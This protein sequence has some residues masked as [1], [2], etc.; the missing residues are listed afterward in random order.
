MKAI[1][2]AVGIVMCSASA[3]GDAYFLGLG[4]LPGSSAS[5][6]YAISPDGTAVVGTT[7]GGFPYVERAFRWTAETGMVDLGGL[8]LGGDGHAYGVC[9]DGSAVVG[10]G[11]NYIGTQAFRWTAETGMVSLGVPTGPNESSVAR[12]LSWDGSVAVGYTWLFQNKAFRWQDGV[13]TFLGDFPGGDLY[14]E[15]YG[16]SADGS[17]VVGRG[18]NSGGYMA[19]RWT[20]TSGLVALGDL[21][22]GGQDSWARD[23]SADGSVIVGRGKSAYGSEAFQWTAPSADSRGGMIGLGDLPGGDF[24]SEALAVSADG[25][26]IVGGSI[27]GDSGYMG[28]AFIWDAE[29]GMRS[30]RDVLTTEYGFDLT[31]WHLYKATGISADGLTMAGYGYNPDRFGTQAW[32]AHIPEP[33]TLSLL[34]LGSLAAMRRTYV[35]T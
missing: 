29:N 20:P 24:F 4:G 27:S 8:P 10:Y 13:T 22:G 34:A 18:T 30:L 35:L 9:A 26:V 15:A 33:A 14:S 12:D 21:P 32:V 7:I 11:N 28:E 16:M 2:I 23:V 5:M 25:S 31:G 6:A 19:F 3:Y 17:V 1:S